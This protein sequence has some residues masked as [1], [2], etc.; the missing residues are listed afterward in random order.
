MRA[1]GCSGIGVKTMTRSCQLALGRVPDIID[2]T[3]HKSSAGACFVCPQAFC[4]NGT[5]FNGMP[6]LRV[7]TKLYMYDTADIHNRFLRLASRPGL[8]L[9]ATPLG[10]ARAAKTHGRSLVENLLRRW[11]EK[12]LSAC[13][14]LAEYEGGL[15]R[16]WELRAKEALRLR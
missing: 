7:I 6:K 8:E 13:A 2:N 12:K 14:E 11:A 3:N 16:R 4:E 5:I 9:I 1:D 15:T 10:N